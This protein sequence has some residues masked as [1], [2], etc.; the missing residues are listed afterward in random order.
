M[1]MFGVPAKRGHTERPEYTMDRSRLPNPDG[2]LTTKPHVTPSLGNSCPSF[3]FFRTEPGADVPGLGR[4]PRRPSCF[5]PGLTQRQESLAS[6][7]HT[8]P[9]EQPSSSSLASLT[10]SSFLPRACG[11][12]GRDRSKTHTATWGQL[13]AP[14]ARHFPSTCSQPARC[15]RTSF[16]NAGGR[17]TRW[18]SP[19]PTPGPP[20]PHSKHS[21]TCP[22]HCPSEPEGPA[23]LAAKGV[24]KGPRGLGQGTPDGPCSLS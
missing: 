4:A 1:G 8:C 22:S 11:R 21:P 24:S 12:R 18:L 6:G 19:R 23:H 15:P 20:R 3:P 16:E 7:Y 2:A 13:F 5:L 10:P 14:T 9:A 17:P